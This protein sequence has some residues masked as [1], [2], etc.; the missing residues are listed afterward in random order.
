MIKHFKNGGTADIYIDESCKTLQ[1]MFCDVPCYASA[2]V[3][4]EIGKVIDVPIECNIPYSE[5]SHMFLYSDANLDSQLSDRVSGM[6]GIT[7]PDSKTIL[8]LASES[9]AQLKQ[10]QSVG[11][12]NSVLQLYDDDVQLPD[13]GKFSEEDLHSQIILSELSVDKQPMQ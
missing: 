12:I 13:G 2:D 8:L 3:N 5:T 11:T 10:G 4:L 7:D 1:V 9:S 6:T